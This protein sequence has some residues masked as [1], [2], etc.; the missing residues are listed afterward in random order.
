MSE[1][2]KLDERN[3][4]V[5][6]ETDE[7]WEGRTLPVTLIKYTSGSMDL[8]C[9]TGRKHK[10][11]IEK[12]KRILENRGLVVGAVEMIGGTGAY[13]PVTT[14]VA[15]AENDTIKTQRRK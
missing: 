6:F 15:S 13:Y 14:Y 10:E 3:E 4:E 1:E 12:A 7:L 5:L 11:I 9:Q 8:H 2:G